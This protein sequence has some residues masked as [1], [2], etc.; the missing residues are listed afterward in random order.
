MSMRCR[1][2]FSTKII[3]ITMTLTHIQKKVHYVQNGT[4][5]GVLRGKG[6]QWPSSDL[7]RGQVQRHRARHPLQHRPTRGE[8]IRGGQKGTPGRFRDW[9]Q[10]SWQWETSGKFSE[11]NQKT[12]VGWLIWYQRR[13]TWNPVQ[14]KR[15][16][17][18]STGGGRAGSSPMLRRTR[19][20]EGHWQRLGPFD[21]G[22]Q[23]DW[24]CLLSHSEVQRLWEYVFSLSPPLY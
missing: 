21:R 19:L 3:G 4:L 12:N 14:S 11:K 7:S 1:Y 6:S 2:L 23:F 20:S 17:W 9:W 13:R 10:R 18:P 5:M 16:W 8:P 24:Q 15:W 22:R